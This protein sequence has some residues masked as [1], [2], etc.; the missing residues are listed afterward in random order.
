MAAKNK[1]NSFSDLP[2]NPFEA[3]SKNP[4]NTVFWEIPDPPLFT[5]LP[6]VMC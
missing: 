5:Q 6:L 2:K 3:I 4:H 1:E